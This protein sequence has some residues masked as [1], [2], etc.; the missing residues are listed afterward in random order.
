MN[1]F[2]AVGVAYYA[3]LGVI[4]LVRPSVPPGMFGGRADTTDAQVE[5]RAVYGG[6]PLAFA[7]LLAA[8]PAA[9]PAV[10]VATAGMA[11]VRAGGWLAEGRR[12]TSITKLALAAKVAVAAAIAAGMRGTTARAGG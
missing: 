12:V 1:R 4:A 9:A 6:L 2:S 5:V 3:G 11:V 10:A 8:S 7:G